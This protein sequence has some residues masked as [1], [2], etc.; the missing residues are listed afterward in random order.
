MSNNNSIKPIKQLII[1]LKKTG[2]RNNKGRITLRAR[3]G[4]HKKKY[5]FIDFKRNLI[6]I[7]AKIISIEYDPNRNANIALICY[8]N[9]IFSYI[10]ATEGLKVGQYVITNDGLNYG[11]KVIK[12]GSVFKLADLNVGDIVHNIENKPGEG[13]KFAR[14]A[15]CYGQ[16]LKKE[17]EQVLIKL[18]SGE[19]RLFSI[20]CFCTLGVVSNVEIGMKKLYKAGQ[21]RWKS[22]RPIVRGVAKNPVDHPHGGRT[23]GGRPSVSPWGKLTKGKK[24]RSV[25]KQNNLIVERRNK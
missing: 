6:G 12:L 21:N 3:G 23:K 18:N 13:A 9:G 2:G 25:R 7:P 5:R 11:K 16:I 15:G 22:R 20:N 24:T 19:K 14:A 1:G 4:G 10:I 17:D 8:S